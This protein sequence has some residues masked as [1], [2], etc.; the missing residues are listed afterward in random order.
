[1]KELFQW[2]PA[3]GEELIQFYREAV[4]TRSYSDQEGE[5]ARLVEAQMKALG[6]DEAWIDPAGN[7]VGRVGTGPGS[8]ILTAIWTPCGST[9]RRPGGPIPSGQSWWT[10]WSMAEAQW[11]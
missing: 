9:I 6:F 3:Q 7:V 4:R 8:S 1:M 10:E 11:I 2:T 5:L